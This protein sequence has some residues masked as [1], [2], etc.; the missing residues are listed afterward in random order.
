MVSLQKTVY[1]HRNESAVRK[2]VLHGIRGGSGLRRERKNPSEK[3]IRRAASDHQMHRHA[4]PC[5]T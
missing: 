2:E 3:G 5:T 1:L 4:L